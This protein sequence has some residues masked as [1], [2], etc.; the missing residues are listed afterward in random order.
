MRNQ[1]MHPKNEYEPWLTVKDY[2]RLLRVTERTVRNWIKSGLL[3][4]KRIGGRIRI[5]PDEVR[6]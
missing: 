4:H 2:A 1:G 5:H 3:R 6:K